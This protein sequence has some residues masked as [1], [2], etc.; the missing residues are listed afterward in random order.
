MGRGSAAGQQWAI[1]LP[2]R[3]ALV[4]ASEGR[5]HL[6]RLEIGARSTGAYQLSYWGSHG[7]QGR[8]ARTGP[9]HEASSWN[10][11]QARN[12]PAFVHRTLLAARAG[13]ET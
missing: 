1:K 7:K 8:S 10:A 5:V 12:I 4:L 3:Y 9:P 6:I 13:D 2:Y 11:A